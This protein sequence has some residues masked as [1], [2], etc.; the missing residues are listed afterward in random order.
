MIPEL[1]HDF[2]RRFRPDAFRTM[3]HGLDAVS[4]TH[5][6]FPIAETPCFFPKSL[7]DE[8]AAVGAELTH[9]LVDDRAYLAR[10][11]AAIPEAWRAADQDAH[12]HFLTADFGLVREPD[13]RLAPRLV[14]MQ[15][16]PSIFAFQWVLSE[17]YR[18]A[19]DLPASLR[20]LLGGLDEAGYWKLLQRVIVAGHDPD[21][22]VLADVEPAKQKTLPDFHVTADRLGIR[23][24]DIA[25]IEPDDRVD[26]RSNR[27]AP[28]LCYRNGRKLVPIR[29]IYNRAIADELVRKQI[30]LRFDYRE[31]FDVEWAGHPNWYFHVSK[32]SLP[33]L[34]HPAVPPAVFLDDWMHGRHLDKLPADRRYW[35]LKP[36]YSFAGQ[37][38]LFAPADEQLSAIPEA[39]RGQYLLQERVTFEPVI[40]TP[41]GPTFAEIRVLYV[42]PDHGRLTPL[43]CL[44]R[45][46][47]GKMM[48][49]DHNMGQSWVGASAAL[50]N[51]K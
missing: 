6:S 38:I 27:T 45:L 8:M 28:R 33:W 29:R 36:L 10:S 22:V 24:V 39:E 34:Q 2:N 41:A 47:R 18:A 48:G 9:R 13:G 32:F 40:D 7:L 15:A 11:L 43:V 21:T 37:G 35:I 31:S 30:R 3:L 17:A 23:I 16:F 51:D 14:E 44:V 25:E 4:R 20:C 26:A 49:V 1:R 46:G 12:P 5:V 42:W 50:F 19:F